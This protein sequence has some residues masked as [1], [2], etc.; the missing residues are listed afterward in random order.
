MFYGPFT[1]ALREFFAR[2]KWSGQPVPAVFAG[3]DR[4]YQELRRQHPK[5]VTND[6][7]R[8]TGRKGVTKQALGDKP[9]WVPFFS[10]LVSPKVYDPSRFNPRSFRGVTKDLQT[11]TAT[12]MRYPRPVTADVSVELWCGT[13]GGWSI[14][15]HVAAQIE[16]E[17]M[18]ESVYLPL[19]WSLPR[20]YK[21]PFNTLEHARQYGKTRC[22]LVSQGWQDSSNLEALDGPKQVRWTWT[23]RIE[24]YLPY[25]LEEARIVRE[26]TVDVVDEN[27]LEVLDTVTGGVED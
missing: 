10:I 5:L 2:A 17:F 24:G 22:R 18:A 27:T 26:F 14:A 3:P 13:V 9:A 25:R 21:S 20:Y 11:G 12:T 1:D 4:A 23:G 15:S 19:D 16:L 7:S 8:V 6:T